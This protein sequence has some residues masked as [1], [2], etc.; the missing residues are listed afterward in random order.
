MKLGKINRGQEEMVGFVVIVVL[1]AVV[2]LIFLA[3]FLRQDP[4]ETNRESRDIYMFL[5]SMME[6]TTECE[7]GFS[8]NF[9]KMSDLVGECQEKD[10]C[11]DGRNSCE[12]LESSLK[13]EIGNAWSVSEEGFVKGY[14]FSSVFNLNLNQTGEEFFLIEEGECL[15][16][17]RGAEYLTSKFP[18]TIV[19][20]FKL[21]F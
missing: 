1:V 20:S 18:G 13:E 9:I 8:G 14:E 11:L 4:V 21:C 2:G 15:E 12:V 17:L 5:E 7:T 6:K 19:S 16:S 10:F 3:I